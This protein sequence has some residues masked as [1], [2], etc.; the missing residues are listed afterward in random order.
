MNRR[1]QEFLTGTTLRVYLLLLRSKR[2]M[3]VREV[4]RALG[5]K[6]PST[7]SYHINKLLDLGLIERV[8]GGEF[9]AVKNPDA[10]PIALYSVFAGQIIPRLLPYAVAFLAMLITYLIVE[11]PEYNPY[12]LIFGIASTLILWVETIRSWL[13]LKSL[14]GEK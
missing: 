13:N 1:K 9:R 3:G 12:A 8:P 11:F 10:L 6:S 5:M 4:Q 7:A 14:T 2:P